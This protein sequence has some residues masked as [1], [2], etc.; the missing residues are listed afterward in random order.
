MNPNGTLLRARMSRISWA[1]A[2]GSSPMTVTAS[3]RAAPCWRHHSA[4][5]SVITWWNCSSGD[6]AGFGR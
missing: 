1:R 2:D 4:S 3:N 6:Q 5:D